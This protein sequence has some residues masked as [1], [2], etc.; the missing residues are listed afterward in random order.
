MLTIYLILLAIKMTAT[1]GA[2][3]MSY[4]VS[5][6]RIAPTGTYILF[7]IGFLLLFA[8][9]VLSLIKMGSIPDVVIN[10]PDQETLTQLLG[11][12]SYM[13]FFAG[14]IRKL[15]ALKALGFKE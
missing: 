6:K 2:S 5:R 11:A 9:Q 4:L 1:L 7:A 12:I 15:A 14:Y 13:L 10:N 8:N 3:L